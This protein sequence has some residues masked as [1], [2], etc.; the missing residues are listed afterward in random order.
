MNKIYKLLDKQFVKKL[1]EKEVLPLYPD[2]KGIKDVE[3]HTPKKY[4]W[5][6]TYHVV[7]EFRTTFT[8]ND[9]KF[10]SAKASADKGKKTLRL[11]CSAHSDE[12]RKN[13]YTALK[14]LWNNGFGFSFLTVP[15]PLF[16][17]DYFK[18]TFYRGVEG[19]NLYNYIR[20]DK[21]KEINEIV[22]KAAEWF[23]KLHSLD[24]QNALNFNKINSRIKTVIP[25]QEHI[26]QSVK[27]KFPEHYQFYRQAYKIFISKEEEF[28]KRTKRY[29]LIHGDA[30]PENII[31]VS[32]RRIAAI[33]FTD[34]CLSDF[35][36]DLGCFLQQ[37][38]FMIMRKIKDRKYADKIKKLF[39]ENYFKN[40]KIELDSDL[41]SR[42]DNYYNWTAIR[43]ATFFIIKDKPEPSRAKPLIEKVGKNLGIQ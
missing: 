22:P 5:E 42:I 8:T 18:G 36:R 3:I 28:F 37:L 24:T 4:I 9:R 11:F 23:A 1:F 35:A 21:R 33:D 38:E 19:H 20:E 6:N 34:I 31:K 10:S 14:Y 12:P 43:T 30:H 2:F 39:L 15:R 41:E 17:S 25:G 40:V 26:F 32:R 7:F 27:E 13:V 29:W 16:Y